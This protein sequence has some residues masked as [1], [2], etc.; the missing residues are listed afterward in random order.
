M[1]YLEFFDCVCCVFFDDWFGVCVRCE[2]IGG[3]WC[4]DV[5]DCVGLGCCSLVVG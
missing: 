4:V 5:V 3:S 1:L 2:C